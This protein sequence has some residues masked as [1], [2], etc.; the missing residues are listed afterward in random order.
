MFVCLGIHE[1][2]KLVE[3]FGGEYEDYRQRVMFMPSFIPV[4]G[5]FIDATRWHRSRDGDDGR[6]VRDWDGGHLAGVLFG[7]CTSIVHG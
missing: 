1:E 2:E 5:E 7:G 4:R 3:R 6:P